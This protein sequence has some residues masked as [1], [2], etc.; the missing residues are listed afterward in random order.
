MDTT[1]TDAKN[2]HFV[3]TG[4]RIFWKAGE[5]RGSIL[6]RP[7]THV[8]RWDGV[9]IESLAVGSRYGCYSYVL[10][11]VTG[12]K[13]TEIPGTGLPGVRCAVTFHAGDVLDEVVRKAWIEVPTWHESE[14]AELRR[15]LR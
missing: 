4:L 3:N 7:N 14:L 15:A 13:V 5:L 12:R 10:V 8:A 6:Y 2:P 9:S 1:H 11:S